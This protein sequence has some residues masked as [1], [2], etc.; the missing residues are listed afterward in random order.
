MPLQPL[1]RLKRPKN[2]C[3]A[4]C[5][6]I[7]RRALS[8]KCAARGWPTCHVVP[9]TLAS[10]HIQICSTNPRAA[11]KRF[12]LPSSP[13]LLNRRLNGTQEDRRRSVRPRVGGC[14]SK[15]A[16]GRAHARKLLHGRAR[17]GVRRA[18]ERRQRGVVLERLENVL[19]I[20]FTDIIACNAERDARGW[21]AVSASTRRWFCVRA[22]AGASAHTQTAA[23][24]RTGER[25]ARTRAT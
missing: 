13:I 2:I 17:A 19:G 8:I 5:A 18:L 20:R 4:R 10:S 14:A 22:R 1:L 23:W 15:P 9:R 6:T 16:R 21:A 25:A 24:V 3:S 11:A 7:F 12:A